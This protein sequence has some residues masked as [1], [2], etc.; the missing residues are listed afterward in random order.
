MRAV[1]TFERDGLRFDVVDGGPADGPVVLLLHGFPQTR[2]SWAAVAG[3]LHADGYRTVAPDQRGYSPGARPRGR[4]AYRIDELV[5]DA[6]AL[7]RA[8][9]DGPVHVVGHDW[10]AVVAWGLAGAHPDLVATVTGVSVPHPGAFVRS[11]GRSLQGLKSWYMLAFQVPGV[12]R[13]LARPGALADVLRRAGQSPEAARRDEA[14][15]RARGPMGDALTAALTWYRAMPLSVTR[16]GIDPHHEPVV[17]PAMLVWSD[18]DVAITR[19]AAEANEPFMAGPYRFEV[20]RGVSH[21]IPD[22]A[23]GRLADL[24]LEHVGGPLR[25]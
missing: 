14:A 17:A 24:L 12:E 1:D 7:A 6:A 9:S 15:L 5:A 11:M 18:G 13:L 4:V 2:D 20:L 16:S 23:P 3:L 21:W 8:V 25:R 19:A 10:G 22:E